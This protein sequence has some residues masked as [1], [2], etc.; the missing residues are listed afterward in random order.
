MS[1]LST[2]DR[3]QST[4]PAELL[5]TEETS[6]DVVD[7]S[8]FPDTNFVVTI[9]DEQIL[10]SSR[11]GDTLT[12]GERGYGVTVAATHPADS[13]VE[14]RVISKHI[15]ELQDGKEN[16]SNKKTT[17]AD[18]SD[19]FYPSQKAVKTAVDAKAPLASPT[20]TGT[21]TLPK[22]VNIK[23]TS[24]DH[25]YQLA[26]SELTA[27]RVV[28]LPLLTGADTY[29]FQAHA[30]TLTNKRIQ[31]RSSTTTSTATLTPALATA[32][33]WQLTAQGEALTIAAPTGTPVLGETIHI[34]I[35]AVTSNRTVS[36][37]ATFKAMGEALKTTATV[38]KTLEIIATY[39]GSQWLASSTEM[40]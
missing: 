17:L 23:D 37:N 39:D 15:E 40:V 3:A 34:M 9:H 36:Y 31:P 8:K 22:A 38:A 30:Q 29:V 5:D 33:V 16:L 32:N 19:A 1:Y 18:D 21:V 11:T 6:F 35:T 24:A 26:V 20:F 4:L 28:T 25:E 14:A 2:K 12:I 27:D 7:G 10:I 13:Y